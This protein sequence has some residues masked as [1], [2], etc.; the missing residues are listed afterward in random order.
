MIKLI[1]NGDDFGYS[2]VFNDKIL[3]L[4][5]KG[6]IKSTTVMVNWLSKD[7]ESQ[8]KELK[9]LYETKRISTGLHLV[10]DDNK[11]VNQQ[12]KEQYKKFGQIFATNPGHLDLHKYHPESVEIEVVRFAEQYNLSVRN[13]GIKTTAKQTTYP[14]FECP[15][16]LMTLDI[17]ME[18]IQKMEDGY[19]YELVSHPGEYDPNSK[20]SLNKER[21]NDYETLIKLQ[22]Y[23]KKRKDIKNVSYL[24]L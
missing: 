24:E 12:I 9:T 4:L 7:Q 21:K 19:S 5:K 2:S 16:C 1:I 18:F 10:I 17:V 20:S 22:E 15:K 6:Y 14:A 23:L 3:D 11:S 8:I 13:S